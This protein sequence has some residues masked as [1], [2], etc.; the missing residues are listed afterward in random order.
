MSFSPTHLFLKIQI[1]LN[2]L[3]E[4][5][6]GWTGVQCNVRYGERRN[7]EVVFL[8]QNKSKKN[9]IVLFF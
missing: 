6:D 9:L 5:M 1:L 3:D 2:A 8:F 4:W 7:R